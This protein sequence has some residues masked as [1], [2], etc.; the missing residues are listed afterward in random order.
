MLNSLKRNK[1]V[2]QI[3][4]VELNISV[5]GTALTPSASG[6]D[7]AFV[8]S[9]TDHGSGDYT[10]TLKEPSKMNLHV[11]SIVAS[12][13]DVTAKVHAVDK[14]SVRVQFKSVGAAP[15]AT[16]ADFSIQILFMDQLAQY[17]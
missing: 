1:Q 16:N 17:F 15:A 7:S 5:D 12:T 10:I 9:V 8:D 11:S 4:Q 2:R 13:A 14:D 6:P 3:G